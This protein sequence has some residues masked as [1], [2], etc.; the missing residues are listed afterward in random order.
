[1]D[2]SGFK[3]KLKERPIEEEKAKKIYNQ[4]PDREIE[5][6]KRLGINSNG[7]NPEKIKF[8]LNKIKNKPHLI[9]ILKL[10]PEDFKKYGL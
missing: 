5:I 6:G 7:I 10:T 4:Y 3:R 1:M 2:L 8:E 9:K